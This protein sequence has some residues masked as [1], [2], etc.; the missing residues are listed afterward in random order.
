MIVYFGF[1]LNFL[2]I[3]F[4][5]FLYLFL[6]LSYPRHWSLRTFFYPKLRPKT[7]VFFGGLSLLLEWFIIPDSSFFFFLIVI[8]LI[9]WG[10]LRNIYLKFLLK[11]VPDM[12]LLLVESSKNKDFISKLANFPRKVSLYLIF[13]IT[14]PSRTHTLRICLNVFFLGAVFFVFYTLHLFYHL[15]PPLN[16]YTDAYTP[17][18][19]VQQ[20]IFILLSAEDYH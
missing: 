15:L 17:I 8:R 10:Y 1:F 3:F 11:Q 7:D 2:L 9:F 14:P 12:S 19:N 5:N 18:L 4:L 13:Q 16:S 6:M 20:S